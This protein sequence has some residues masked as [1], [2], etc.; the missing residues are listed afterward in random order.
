MTIRRGEPW[1][2]SASV[3][4]DLFVAADDA[5]ASRFVATALEAGRKVP[6]FGVSG[7]DLARTMGGGAPGRFAAAVTRAPVDLLRVEADGRRT[8]AV[9]HVVVGS[10]FRP[11]LCFAMNAQFVGKLDLAPRSHPN[12]GRLDTLVV[13]PSMSLRARV[14]ARR[15]ARSGTHVPHPQLAVSQVAAV[16][17]TFDRARTIRVDGRRWGSARTVCVT[18]LPDALVV[19]A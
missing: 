2:E 5:T 16:T 9:A 6:P 4:P 18:V 1:G 19:H 17:W 8:V 14:Q 11:G 13:N 15:R 12:D 10:W 3:P 7:G